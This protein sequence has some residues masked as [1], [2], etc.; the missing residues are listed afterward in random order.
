MNYQVQHSNCAETTV[1][2]S[3]L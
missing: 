1:R 3:P 2:R